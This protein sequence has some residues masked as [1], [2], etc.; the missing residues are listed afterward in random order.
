M[1]ASRQ[2][3]GHMKVVN[4]RHTQSATVLGHA[5]HLLDYTG[6]LYQVLLGRS[7]SPRHDLGPSM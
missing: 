6:N 4:S 2:P 1:I 7:R 3:A 5:F